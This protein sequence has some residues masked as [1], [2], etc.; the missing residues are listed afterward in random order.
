MR[1]TAGDSRKTE[2]QGIPVPDLKNYLDDW[3]LE[4]QLHKHTP[5]S[6]QSRKARIGKFFWFLEHKG[7]SEV[8][9]PELKCFLLYL[10]ESHLEAGG[11]WGNPRM[12]QPM[13]PISIHGY[14]R[15]LKAFFNFLMNEELIN[16]NPMARIKPPSAKTEIKQPVS[17]EHIQKLLRAC[18]RSRYYR[19]DEAILLLLVDTGLRASELCQLKREDLDLQAQTLKVLGKGNKYRTVFLGLSTTRA[20][21]VYL[22]QAERRPE[23]QSEKSCAGVISTEAQRRMSAAE[24]RNLAVWQ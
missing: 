1:R 18:K 7:I 16:S 11:R 15:I 4:A 9:A 17:E 10:N 3:N 6:V 5:Q 12:T 24:W 14:F 8:G 21:K 23:K 22:R 19:R 13:R 20:L 2:Q